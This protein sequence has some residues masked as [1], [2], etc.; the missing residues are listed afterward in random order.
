[1]RY[2]EAV[3][4]ISDEQGGFRS[5]RGCPD[6]I[7]IFREMLASRRERKLPTFCTFVDVRKAYDTVWREKAYVNMHDAGINGKLWRQIQVMHKGL[8]RRV[9]HPSASQ[10]PSTWNVEL[11]RVR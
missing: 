2:S 11:P 4:A 5:R 6:Q 8:T 9:M 3:G 10:S 7:L 1:M